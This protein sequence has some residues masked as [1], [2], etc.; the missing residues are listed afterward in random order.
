MHV[1]NIFIYRCLFYIFN[2]AKMAE[3]QESIEKYLFFSQTA[4]LNQNRLSY[5]LIVEYDLQETT[6]N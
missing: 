5:W 1:F 4:L 6:F 2:Q 3:D